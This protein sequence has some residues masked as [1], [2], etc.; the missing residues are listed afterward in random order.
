MDTWKLYRV[1]RFEYQMMTGYTA[2]NDS[3]S[4]E[5]EKMNFKKHAVNS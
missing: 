1:Q 2:T 4:P 3:V 5:Q